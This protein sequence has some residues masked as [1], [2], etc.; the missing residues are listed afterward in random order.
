MKTTVPGRK[1]TA[2]TMSMLAV[3]ALLFVV[4]Q[5]TAKACPATIMHSPADTILV[6]KQTISKKYKI[7]LYP[8]ASHEVLF[9]SASGPANHT[10]GKVYQLYLFDVEGNLVKQANIRNKQT[11]VLNNI[12]K[13]RYMFEVFSDDERIE[14][15]QLFVR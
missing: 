9:F 6:Q 7:R 14:N 15:G 5:S 3:T 12:E 10:D 2:R 8:N 11:T 4:F 1:H 13:G